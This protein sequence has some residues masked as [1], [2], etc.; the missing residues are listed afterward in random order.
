M[1]TVSRRFPPTNFCNLFA[2]CERIAGA[3]GFDL[4]R[5]KVE[6]FAPSHNPTDLALVLCAELW[7]VE[8]LSPALRRPHIRRA[9]LTHQREMW[10]RRAVSFAALFYNGGETE[11]ALSIAPTPF[12]LSWNTAHGLD[13]EGNEPLLAPLLIRGLYCLG[14]AAAVSGLCRHY[15]YTLTERTADILEARMQRAGFIIPEQA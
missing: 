2:R 10:C 1:L 12:A 7:G 14:Y 3:F 9:D 13:T 11:F 6:K 5:A 8:G 4:N 15:N